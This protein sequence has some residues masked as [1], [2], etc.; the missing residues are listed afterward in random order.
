MNAMFN[1]MTPKL[2]RILEA[3]EEAADA[4]ES[5]TIL[6]AMP[7]RDSGLCSSTAGGETLPPEELAREHLSFER[8]LTCNWNE[9][10]RAGRF[11]R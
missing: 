2:A 7:C 8:D 6:T 4:T 3:L 11:A 1:A 5:S 10:R 9:L